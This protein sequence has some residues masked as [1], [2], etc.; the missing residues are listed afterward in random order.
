MNEVVDMYA[1]R[2]FGHARIEKVGG[3]K[4]VPRSN[5]HRNK[6]N[7]QPT[8][9][10]IRYQ[11]RWYRVH[12]MGVNW[13]YIRVTG[14]NPQSLIHKYSVMVD[15]SDENFSAILNERYR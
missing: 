2:N 14:R 8:D 13:Y 10:M 6:E 7:D 12:A 4:F 15:I 3:M 9:Y 1:A 11:N 5:T